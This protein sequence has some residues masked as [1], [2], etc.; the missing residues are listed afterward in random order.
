[1]MLDKNGQWRHFNGT[2]A[3]QGLFDGTAL[4]TVSVRVLNCKK[5]Q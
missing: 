2:P 5:V 4:Q 3:G 1:M